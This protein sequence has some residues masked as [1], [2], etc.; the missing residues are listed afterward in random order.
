MHQKTMRLKPLHGWNTSHTTMKIQEPSSAYRYPDGIV[1][2]LNTANQ[3]DHYFVER[4]Y[5]LQ[6]ASGIKEAL[7]SKPKKQKTVEN[8]PQQPKQKA[9]E[10]KSQQPKKKQKKSASPAKK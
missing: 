5:A 3:A 8:K 4:N 7:F 9:L 6:L 1:L 2:T 10:N